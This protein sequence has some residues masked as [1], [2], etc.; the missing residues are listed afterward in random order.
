MIS[1]FILVTLAPHP[2]LDA[3]DESPEPEAPDGWVCHP[4]GDTSAPG[5]MTTNADDPCYLDPSGKLVA[6]GER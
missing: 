1:G 4:V 6:L 5:T 2:W 3:C